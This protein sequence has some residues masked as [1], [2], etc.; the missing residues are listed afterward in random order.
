MGATIDAVNTTLALF[1]IGCSWTFYAVSHRFCNPT[2]SFISPEDWWLGF[3]ILSSS[4]FMFLGV[5]LIT[6]CTGIVCL[7]FYAIAYVGFSVSWIVVGGFV[8]F[9]DALVCVQEGDLGAIFGVVCWC[10]LIVQTCIIPSS[11]RRAK[12][13]YDSIN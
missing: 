10:L 2:D 4:G 5:L 12:E 3:A 6:C 8:W 9:R 13:Q 11:A 1:L 7:P